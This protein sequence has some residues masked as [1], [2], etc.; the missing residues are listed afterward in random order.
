VTDAGLP[1]RRRVSGEA[2]T[3]LPN[4]HTYLLPSWSTARMISKSR[5]ST[6]SNMLPAVFAPDLDRRAKIAEADDSRADW[7]GA[8]IGEAFYGRS[9]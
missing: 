5:A 4:F 9:S 7:R 3:R 6:V 1:S 2:A 8:A